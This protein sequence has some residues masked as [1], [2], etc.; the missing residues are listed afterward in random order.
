MNKVSTQVL[1]WAALASLAV[2]LGGAASPAIGQDE[3]PAAK[4]AAAKKA[5]KPRGRLP[6]YYGEV[7]NEKQRET[8]YKIQAEYKSKID[9]LKAELAAL[10]KER[11][12]KVAAVLTP[13]QAKKVKE[14]KAKA[15]AERA[16]KRP[17]KK[18]KASKAPAE[19]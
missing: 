18:K 19:K 13:E 9:A 11:N 7:V 4:K 15:K 10:M 12:K 8:I 3:K 6:A 1:L 16:K 14:L 17:A 2:L 5:K